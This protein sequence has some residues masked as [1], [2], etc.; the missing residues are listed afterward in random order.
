MLGHAR[1]PLLLRHHVG[2]DGVGYPGQ[3]PGDEPRRGDHRRRLHDAE[4]GSLGSNLA[5]PRPSPSIS[6]GLKRLAQSVTNSRSWSPRRRHR[7]GRR[8]GSAHGR[9]PCTASP[10]RRTPTSSSVSSVSADPGGADEENEVVTAGPVQVKFRVVESRSGPRKNVILEW[11]WSEGSVEELDPARQAKLLG[12]SLSQVTTTKTIEDSTDDRPTGHAGRCRRPGTTGDARRRSS[13]SC[14]GHLERTGGE[15]P[16]PLLVGQQ[17]HLPALLLL[18]RLQGHA[19]A[20]ARTTSP[21]RPRSIWR[22]SFGGSRSSPASPSASSPRRSLDPV[23][24]EWAITQPAERRA[25]AAPR[26]Q[27]VR[28]KRHR[29]VSGALEPGYETVGAAHLG[30]PWRPD[31]APSTARPARSSPFPPA[32]RRARPCSGTTR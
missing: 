4:R 13:G 15:R 17:D 25:G 3:D 8:A 9:R 11:D 27:V 7:H 6:R 18:L 12:D 19:H 32:W 14:P 24:S 31:R 30:H 10:G 16:P 21:G 23:I 22:T 26:A 2:H 20:T 5:R 28:A 1:L 29:P